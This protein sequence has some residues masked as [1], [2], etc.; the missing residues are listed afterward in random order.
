MGRKDIKFYHAKK[1]STTSATT[2]MTEYPAPTVGL[3][4]QVFTFGKD[5][6]A[7]RF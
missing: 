1:S 5:K 6:D 7:A 4:D 3:E 2:S